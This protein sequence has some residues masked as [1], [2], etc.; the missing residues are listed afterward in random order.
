MNEHEQSALRARKARKIREKRRPSRWLEKRAERAFDAR[1]VS[2][3]AEGETPTSIPALELDL[4]LEGSDPTATPS[5]ASRPRRSFGRHVVAVV[6]VSLVVCI[7]ALARSVTLGA[8]PTSPAAAP[9]AAPVFAPWPHAV[10]DTSTAPTD[11]A[12]PGPPA[13]E[14][15][16]DRSPEE[17]LVAR[18]DARR[19][20]EKGAGADAVVAARASVAL[21][22]TDAE[23]WLV[24][25]A[26]YQLVG[27]MREA[28]SA[29][30]S[31][32]RVATRGR[33]W[34]CRALL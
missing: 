8:S 9:L 19:L 33:S 28:R 20:L 29:F 13:A 23:A 27:N 10:V 12:P 5:L 7:A 18:E 15:A 1:A 4:E 6:A 21:D 11:V 17:A 31:C 22:P 26:A 30:E 32:T 16:P 14:S 3:F 34:E 2:F 24:L 25:G